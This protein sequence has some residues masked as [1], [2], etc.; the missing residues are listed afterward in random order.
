M[1]PIILGTWTAATL[2]CAVGLLAGM[3]RARPPAVA[4]LAGEKQD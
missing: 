4:E 1:L 2:A 3:R